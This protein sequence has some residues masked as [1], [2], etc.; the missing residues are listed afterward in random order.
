MIIAFEGI[1]GC[2]KTT[3][4][5]MLA[6]KFTKNYSTYKLKFPNYDNY[7]GGEV[8]K[9]LNGE[10]GKLE[11]SLS[12]AKLI[13]NL[14]AL[15]R[16]EQLKDMNYYFNEMVLIDR[17]ILSNIALQGA[18]VKDSEFNEFFDYI[19]NLEINILGLPHPTITFYFNVSGNKSILSNRK[20]DYTDQDQDLHEKDIDFLNRANDCYLK[21]IMKL[22]DNPNYIIHKIDCLDENDDWK[23]TEIIHKEVMTMIVLTT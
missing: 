18:K 10:Y 1:D 21:T 13:S 8:G 15:D 16:Y 19:I 9:Y 17:Y 14:Y 2:G 4:Y 7:M 6:E 11:M 23:S 22:C 12:N 3:Q 20:R 5:N